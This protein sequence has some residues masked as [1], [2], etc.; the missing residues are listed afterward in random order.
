MVNLKVSMVEINIKRLADK[1]KRLKG[2][3]MSTC[4]TTKQKVISREILLNIFNLVRKGNSK[5]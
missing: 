4:F 3:K 1:Y 2:T 5:K